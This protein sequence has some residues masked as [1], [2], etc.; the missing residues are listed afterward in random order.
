MREKNHLHHQNTMIGNFMTFGAFAIELI[1][2]KWLLV[3]NFCSESI[4]VTKY[5]TFGANMN[6]NMRS[7]ELTS[8][9]RSRE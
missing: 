6:D 2:E 1:I 7:V 3:I 8:C 5:L 9:Q 4:V